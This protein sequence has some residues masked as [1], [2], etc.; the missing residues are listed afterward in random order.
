MLSRLVQMLYRPFYAMRWT[1]M[2]AFFCCCI[3][4]HWESQF[5]SSGSFWQVS[6]RPFDNEIQMP[7]AARRK[8]ERNFGT[9]RLCFFYFNLSVL[10]NPLFHHLSL[11][12]PIPFL[13]FLQSRN[14]WEKKPVTLRHIKWV[15]QTSVRAVDWS[16]HS[17]I[18]MR[19]QKWGIEM[20]Y[21]SV[22][23]AFSLS[24]YK[25]RQSIVPSSKSTSL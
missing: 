24:R 2:R 3:R 22:W 11:S 8:D 10:L 20:I 23:F 4:I 6:W 21:L 16:W 7:R 17:E 15:L 12:L 19:T 14:L 25:F 1:T 13:S 5:C 9:V 18:C